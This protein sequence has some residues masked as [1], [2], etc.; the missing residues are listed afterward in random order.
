M[1]L[2]L[3]SKY[4]LELYNNFNCLEIKEYNRNN[5]KDNINFYKRR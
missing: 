4:L 5:Y 3:I 2:K 1:N